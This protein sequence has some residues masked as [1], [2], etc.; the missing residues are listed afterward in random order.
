MFTEDRMRSLLKSVEELAGEREM[1]RAF[2]EQ[3]FDFVS[4]HA[5][6]IRKW[7]MARKAKQTKKAEPKVVEAVGTAVGGHDA[8]ELGRRLEQAQI[9]AINQAA[10]DNISDPAVIRERMAAAVQAVLKG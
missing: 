5:E 7:N 3:N 8:A 4:R 10:A 6:Y 9:D 2:F 1:H